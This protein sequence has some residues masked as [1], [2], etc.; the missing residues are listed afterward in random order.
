MLASPVDEPAAHN[1]H[2]KGWVPDSV[3]RVGR[4][5]CADGR[6]GRFVVEV[7]IV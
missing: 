4:R 2:T 1:T 5:C 3:Q 6:R 7:F